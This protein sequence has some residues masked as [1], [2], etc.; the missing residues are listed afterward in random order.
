MNKN[1]PDP[2]YNMAPLF[3]HTLEEHNQQCLYPQSAWKYPVHLLFVIFIDYSDFVAPLPLLLWGQFL[4]NINPVKP[5]P[6]HLIPN[7]SICV[8]EN[9][10]KG[11]KNHHFFL[12]KQ[13]HE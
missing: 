2:T 4:S 9:L 5:L 1:H 7:I 11:A 10:R 3:L 8:S 12:K 6:D 13:K